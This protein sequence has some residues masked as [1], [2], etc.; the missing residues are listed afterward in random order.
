MDGGA[1]VKES[2]GNK[3]KKDSWYC[4]RE[5]QSQQAYGAILRG[6]RNVHIPDIPDTLLKSVLK[7]SS[8]FLDFFPYPNRDPNLNHQMSSHIP[9]VLHITKRRKASMRTSR[10][11]KPTMTSDQS[12]GGLDFCLL[13]Q[14]DV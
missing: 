14:V 6:R 1:G 8:R 2:G 12:C 13:V 9:R 3:A 7:V 4:E 11:R 5:P 10:F